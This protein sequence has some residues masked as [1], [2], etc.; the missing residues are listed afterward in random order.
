M[1]ESFGA[2]LR[3]R[4][5]AAG[6]SLGELARRINYHKSYLSKIENDVKQ[7]G[8]VLARLCDDV[9]EAGGDLAAAIASERRPPAEAVPD[10]ESSGSGVWQLEL[11]PRAAMSFGDGETAAGSGSPVLSA[12]LGSVPAQHDADQHLVAAVRSAFDQH[13]AVGMM[14]SPV[15]VLAPVIAQVHTARSLASVLAEPARTDLLMLA[16]RLAEYAGWM[17]QEAGDDR[18]AVWWTRRAVDL[19]VGRHGDELT[20]YA[21]VRRAEI[22]LYRH[23]AMTTIELAA[24][25]QSSAAAGPRV[26]ALAARCEA[27][28]YAIAG[29]LAGCRR[30]LD[31]AA[32]WFS[33][34]GSSAP[35]TGPMIG[36]TSGA[37]EVQLA[38]GWSLVELGRP[39]QA[40]ELL[41][42]QLPSFSPLSRRARARFAVRQALAYGQAGEV[43]QACLVVSRTLDDAHRVDSATIRTDLRALVRTLARWRTDAR[44]REIQPSVLRALASPVS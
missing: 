33:A 7:P 28:G 12:R 43:E 24:R 37:D 17:S 4:R 25:A 40:A 22:A 23:D 29:D 14:A 20:G 21:L 3:A 38:L 31:R 8:A 42:T 15:F 41:E 30:A 11:L 34:A 19:G 39:R 9:L 10:D 13:R 6:I 35:A 44:V 2:Q 27:Q 5:L 32:E 1:S 18:A 36:S 16:S 26:L